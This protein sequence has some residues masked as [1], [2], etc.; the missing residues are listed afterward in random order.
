MSILTDWSAG[1]STLLNAAHGLSG[2]IATHGGMIGDA[3]E[4]FIRD[5]LSR[6]LP[7][8]LVVY[9]FS[10][11]IYFIE[12]RVQLAIRHTRIPVSHSALTS[13]LPLTIF[14][15]CRNGRRYGVKFVR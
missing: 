11:I 9:A 7:Q 4:L 2:A 1:I 15:T 12:F 5:I 14:K 10:C 8:G 13:L 6:F 3:R